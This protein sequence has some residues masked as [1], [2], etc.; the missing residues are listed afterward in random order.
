MVPRAS[1]VAIS[2]PMTFSGG[3][4]DRAAHL[5]TDGEYARARAAPE[6]RAIVVGEGPA[7]LLGETGGGSLARRPLG[8]AGEPILLGVGSDGAPLFALAADASHDGALMPL[9]QAVPELTPADAALAGYAAGLIAWQRTTAHCGR[10]GTAMASTQAGH[11]RRCPACGLT[12]YPRTDPVVT[13]VVEAGDRCLLTRRR[14]ALEGM[15]SA[16]AGFVEPGETP[17]EAIVRETREEVGVDVIASEYLGAQP[18]PFP[19]ALMLGFRAFADPQT[20]YAQVHEPDELTDA[21]WFTRAEL[22]A[23]LAAG[24]MT[25]PPPL[26]IGHH[27]IV[28]FLDRVA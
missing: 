1:I 20:T 24:T 11:S 7:V 4:L 16:L 18:W 2:E 8:E 21:R 26:A 23:A 3:V 10:C 15:W 27:L 19:G 17:E 12:S 6:A 28:A 22:S 9:R 14:G 13:M 25:I 5:R